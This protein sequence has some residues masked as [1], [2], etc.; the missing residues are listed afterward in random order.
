MKPAPSRKEGCVYPSHDQPLPEVQEAI[1]KIQSAAERFSQEL[2]QLKDQI[3]AKR[4]QLRRAKKALSALTGE[5]R[6]AR[7]KRAA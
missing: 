7:K 2:S 4:A 3:K 5:V 1:Q 6:T